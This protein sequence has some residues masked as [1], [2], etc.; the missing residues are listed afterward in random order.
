MCVPLIIG[1][2]A[3]TVLTGNAVVEARLAGQASLDAG[4]L[5]G[6]RHAEALNF[7]ATAQRTAAADQAQLMG[8]Y[9]L[10]AAASASSSADAAHYTQKIVELEQRLARLGSLQRAYQEA[11]QRASVGALVDLARER[12]FRAAEQVLSPPSLPT[13]ESARSCAE[14]LIPD[15]SLGLTLSVEVDLVSRGIAA[16][17]A[18]FGPPAYEVAHAAALV[19]CVSG[20]LVPGLSL[21]QLPEQADHI[22][23]LA[24]GDGLVSIVGL[25]LSRDDGAVTPT[26]TARLVPAAEVSAY[27]DW[28]AALAP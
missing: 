17:M 12:G 18:P 24:R 2:F 13:L 28:R 7:S 23:E 10:S 15:P 26:Y 8:L 20:G 6:Q 3:T 1:A 14:S 11:A 4:W 16:R 27:A 9:G 21:Q 19:R 25:R 22:V 5:T